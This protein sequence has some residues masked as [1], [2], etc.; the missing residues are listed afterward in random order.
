MA[1]ADL[2]MSN[3]DRPR[4]AFNLPHDKTQLPNGDWMIKS[5]ALAL[6]VTAPTEEEALAEWLSKFQAALN[7]LPEDERNRWVNNNMRKVELP[8]GYTPGN[9]PGREYN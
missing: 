1:G 5:D 9:I 3:P 6:S 4:V 2:T 7:A 8:D